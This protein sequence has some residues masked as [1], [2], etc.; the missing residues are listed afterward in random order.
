MIEKIKQYSQLILTILIIVLILLNFK[1]CSDKNNTTEYNKELDRS[2]I[3]ALSDSIKV[4]VDKHGKKA[5]EKLTASMDLGDFTSSELFKTLSKEKQQYYLELKNTKGLLAS[6]Q[7]GLMSQ[8]HLIDSLSY[9]PKVIISSNDSVLCIRKN[10]DFFYID[11]VKKLGLTQIIKLTLGNKEIWDINSKYTTDLK[12]DYI[13][14]KDKSI[15]LTYKF[16]D[17][18]LVLLNS[19][20]Y[21]IPNYKPT[22]QEKFKDNTIKVGI[23]VGGIGLGYFAGR[24]TH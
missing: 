14:Q 22:W 24:L 2:I 12:I 19:N 13:R 15:L 17:P 10:S 7:A 6:L 16:S 23:L 9:S 4:I 1:Q 20:S 21:I 8:Q 18:N 5:F 3:A 11:T